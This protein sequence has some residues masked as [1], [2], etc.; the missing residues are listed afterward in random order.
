MQA[1]FYQVM[2]HTAGIY[3][4]YIFV[5][6]LAPKLTLLP[7]LRLDIIV[8]CVS[9]AV[10]SSFSKSDVDEGRYIVGH[11]I[12]YIIYNICIYDMIFQV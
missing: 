1:C 2:L 10:S 12:Y 3:F 8:S 6:F 4:D 7:R 5:W 11:T 9:C